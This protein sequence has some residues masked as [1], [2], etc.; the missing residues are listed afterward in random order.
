MWIGTKFR[1]AQVNTQRFG[2]AAEIPREIAR[3]ISDEIPHEPELRAELK[4]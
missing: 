1:R 3:K 4:T 2:F